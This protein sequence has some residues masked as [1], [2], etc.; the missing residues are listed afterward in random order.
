MSVSAGFGVY[1]HWPFCEAICPYCDFNVYRSRGRDTGPLLDALC[2]DLAAHRALTGPIVLDSLFLGGGT[3]S[4]LAASEVERLIE[5][6]RALWPVA[7]GIEITLEA[8]PTN[9][10]AQRFADFASAGVNRVSL[11][12]QAFDDAAL[13][14]LGRW[15]DAAQA[16]RAVAL[17]QAAFARVSLDLI[18]ARPEQSLPAW[19]AELSAALALGVDHLSIY[20][21]TIEE[22]T[23]FA[24]A[25][26][27]GSLIAPS[28]EAAAD[29]YDATQ[30]L[31]AAAGMPAY[32]VSNHAR[33]PEAQSRHNLIYW[34]S[35][36]WAGVGPGAH[37]RLDL[38]DGRTATIA[39]RK[40]DAYVAQV[41]ARGCGWQERER[42]DGAAVALEFW[43]MGVRLADGVLRAQAQARG[44]VWPAQTIADLAADGLAEAQPD[45]MR[46][47]PRGRLL[48]DGLAQRLAAG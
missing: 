36:Q 12:V 3:P 30:A 2:A 4:L 7:E 26:A 46:L 5:T 41:A 42:L 32:E 45:A 40:P 48:A 33:G 10:E 19:E 16:F 22:G 11:G 34:R 21:L 28:P 1:L 9:A 6:C 39:A 31:C 23:A 18:A 24:R 44:V 38:A 47:T 17:A 15:H 25:A 35:G 13:K 29:L 20:H 43:L 27:R 14:R 37:G 8:N